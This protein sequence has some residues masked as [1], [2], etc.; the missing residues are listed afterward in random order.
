[1]SRDLLTQSIE[2]Y[3]KIEEVQNQSQIAM[4][5]D[6]MGLA[7]IEFSVPALLADLG[8]TELQPGTYTIKVPAGPDKANRSTWDDMV[9]PKGAI[10]KEIIVDTHANKAGAGSMTPQLGATD[11]TAV[12]SIGLV[13]D[14]VKKGLVK[15]PFDD[16]VRVVIAGD[17]VTEG[18]FTIFIRYFLG[19]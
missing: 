16:T 3:K 15:L 8:I 11:L 4:F 6:R 19:N 13:D 12:D 18:A 2:A 14:S 9:I 5:G 10:Y 7:V 1:M 17:V